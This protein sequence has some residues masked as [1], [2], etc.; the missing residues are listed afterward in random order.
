MV[1]EDEAMPISDHSRHQRR[2]ACSVQDARAFLERHRDD[3]IGYLLAV[4]VALENSTLF[5]AN[6][7]VVQALMEDM[8][9]PDDEEAFNVSTIGKLLEKV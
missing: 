1:T 6:P 5:D 2:L 3:V 9:E 8:V 7:E 4:K